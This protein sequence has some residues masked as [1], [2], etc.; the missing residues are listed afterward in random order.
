MLGKAVDICVKLG[1]YTITVLEES[2]EIDYYCFE[3]LK[4]HKVGVCMFAI[5][6]VLKTQLTFISTY[7]FSFF[8]DPPCKDLQDTFYFT[9]DMNSLFRTHTHLLLKLDNLKNVSHRCI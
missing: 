6:S 3:A 8:K 4:C 1:Y 5:T 7:Y 9:E 2:P